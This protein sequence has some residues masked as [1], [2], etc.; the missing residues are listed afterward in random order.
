V[1][2]LNTDNRLMSATTVTEEYWRAHEHL[3]FTWDELKDLAL[4]S[5]DSA[6]L[7]H[8]I[9]LASFVGFAISANVGFALLSGTSA[10]YR[11]YSRWGLTP[12]DL[13]RVVLFYSVTIW[14]GLFVVGGGVLAF[15]PPPSAAGLERG[16]LRAAGFVLLA[17]A[18]AYLTLAALRRRPLRAFGFEIP[19][20][21]LRLVPLQ[22]VLGSADWLLSS[23][24]L[25]ALLPPGAVGYPQVLGT[26]VAAQVVGVLSHVPGGLGVF[27]SM[28]LLQ[29]DGHVPTDALLGS[30]VLFRLTFFLLP[31][32]A[33]L[34][35]LL[36]DEFRQRRDVVRQWGSTFGGLTFDLAPKVLSLF[37]F[38]AGALLLFSGATPPETWR[39]TALARTL[40]LGVFEGAHLAGSLSG[41]GLVLASHGVARRLRGTHRAAMA[42]LAIG[43]AASVLKAGAWEQAAVLAVFLAVFTATRREFDRTAPFWA[44]RFSPFWAAAVV[45]VFLASVWLGTFAYRHVEFSEALWWRFELRQNAPRFLRGSVAAALVLLAFAFTRLLRRAPRPAPRPYRSEV[46]EAAA[47][48]VRQ[49]DTQPLLVYGRDKA[50]LWNDTRDGYVMYG[51]TGR[52]WVALG[53]P[54]CASRDAATRLIRDFV[55]SADDYDSLPVFLRVR[56]EH[57]HTYA[58]HGLLVVRIADE[59]RVA[60][61]Q[62]PDD[63]PAHDALRVAMDDANRVG[64]RVRIVPAPVRGAVVHAMREVSDA[65]MGP[66]GREP[67]AFSSPRFAPAYVRRFPVALLERAGRLEAFA[68]LWTTADRQEAT[69]GLLRFRPGTP[70]E[71]IAVLY[72][73]LLRWA[74]GEGFR[75]FSLGMA[76][77]EPLEPAPVAKLWDGAWAPEHLCGGTFLDVRELR[78]FR[79]AFSPVWT[80]RYLAYPGGLPLPRVLSAVATLA[81]GG[82]MPGTVRKRPAAESER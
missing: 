79:E 47:L 41:A 6:F 66:A 10:R 9:A 64:V 2:S 52:T 28:V 65:W 60:L 12:A 27:E 15:L 38:A 56:Q 31:L 33:A 43:V 58:D 5:F 13:S 46:R 45:A 4:M 17:V 67:A 7:R 62:M 37:V 8:R 80:P 26:F 82:G 21:S 48:A 16:W 35:L 34:M 55:E 75:H 24:V 74:R 40:P 68:S 72:A 20:P 22:F 49:P 53:D 29:L 76:P 42:L 50:L 11:F 36:L 14:L 44:T 54:V 19:I 77:P 32:S 81:A 71:T 70:P 61:A 59:A 18:A 3:G 73:H 25:F 63:G 69:A 57:L 30:L 51:V 1:L 78:P 39:L 23:A